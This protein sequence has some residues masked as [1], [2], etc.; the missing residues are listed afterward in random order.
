MNRLRCRGAAAIEA[1]IMLTLLTPLLVASI[2]F[3]RL[4]L[5]GAALE[6]A[7]S[8][9]A[10]VLSTVPAESLHDTARTAA[11]LAAARS[12][13]DETLAAANV[14]PLDLVVWFSCDPG[15]CRT[16]PSGSVPAKVGVY[17][18]FNFPNADL[19]PNSGYGSSS[20]TWLEERAE[21]GR[22]K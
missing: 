15:D 11:A 14:E 10:R 9:A 7:A 17:A 2:Y 16:V 12:V 3:G 13:F 1:A 6:Q 18:A 22:E 5:A 8:N 21:V 19:F 20:Y 4:A